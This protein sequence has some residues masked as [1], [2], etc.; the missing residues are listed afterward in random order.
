LVSS[1]EYSSTPVIRKKKGKAEI[2]KY[3]FL[4]GFENTKQVCDTDVNQARSWVEKAF[5]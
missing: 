4:K 2:D 3:Q 1:S 5:R